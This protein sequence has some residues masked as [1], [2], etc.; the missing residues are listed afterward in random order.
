MGSVVTLGLGRL[1][2]DWGKNWNYTNHSKLFLPSDGR[3]V[4]HYYFDPETEG[5]VE[6]FK[7]GLARPLR[8]V[9]RRIE[10]LGYTLATAKRH[11]EEDPVHVPDF[12]DN[13]DISFDVFAR[14]LAAV[15]VQKV[16]LDPWFADHSLG[17]FAARSIL[18][19]PEFTK[20]A[21]NLESLT[22]H[23]GQFFENLDP[24]VTLRLLAQNAENLSVEVQ[25]R[26]ADLVE[27]G[28]ADEASIYEGLSEHDRY[29]IVTEGSS[30]GAVIRKAMELLR[31]DIADFFNFVDMSENYPFTGAGNLFRFCQGLAQI[32]IQNRVVIV[33]D[34]DAAGVEAER[35]VRRLALPRNMQVVRLPDLA[36][37]RAFRTI[38]PNGSTH[39]DINGRAVSIEMFLDLAAGP[40]PCVRWTSYNSSTECYQGELMEKERYTR[41]F[42]DL[43]T[44]SK[45]YDCSKLE[46][47]LDH[48]YDAIV[49][50]G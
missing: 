19:D 41:A 20:T 50:A 4:S 8:S 27:N 2:I 36:D 22:R 44:E 49:N 17:D 25:W 23:D 1:E 18:R 28:W 39:E 11:F 6:E 14:A 33:F 29:L 3:P 21:K 13:P 16:T 48:V 7:P 30:D 10:L 46:L 32:K 31:P 38:G 26:Y 34:N 45:G 15:D 12:Y 43:R 5:I 40:Q 35:K 24:Y 42:L 47:L 37:C 9:K